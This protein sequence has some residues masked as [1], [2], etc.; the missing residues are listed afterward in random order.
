[1][2][3]QTRHHSATW[4]IGRPNG[5]ELSRLASPRIHSNA[6]VDAGLAKS[7]PASLVQGLPTC[8]HRK[9]SR[10]VQSMRYS[11]TS[12]DGPGTELSLLTTGSLIRVRQPKDTDYGVTGAHLRSTVPEE[13]VWVS[14]GLSLTLL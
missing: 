11:E 9:R 14:T 10:H 2:V 4:F 5:I 13:N 12:E 8:I 1:M 6:R 3:T 7:A